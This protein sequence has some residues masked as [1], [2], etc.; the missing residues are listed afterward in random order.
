[1]DDDHSLL[2]TELKRLRPVAASRDLLG[3]IESEV[4]PA[5]PRPLARWTW[6]VLPAAA[7]F[8]V[9]MAVKSQHS[10]IAPEKPATVLRPQTTRIE[11]KPVRAENVLLSAQDEGLVTFADG[12]P[13]RR[14]RQSYV[15]T[16]VW[17]NAGTNASLT[18][19][20]P[21]EEVRVVPVN[22]Q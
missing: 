21:R 11:F 18:L 10:T 8:A 13:A 2:E 19:S 9:V 20:L 12:I 17:K 15:D 5:A 6:L 1:M 22:F 4:Q 16:I 3:R 14:V 7:A